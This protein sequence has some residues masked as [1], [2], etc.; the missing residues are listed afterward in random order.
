MRKTDRIV[1]PTGTLAEMGVSRH[2][3]LRAVRA[4]EE[5]GLVAVTRHV[6]RKTRV[7]VLEVPAGSSIQGADRRPDLKRGEVE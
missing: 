2:A 7:R 3:A 6:G 5:A 4:L 1:L